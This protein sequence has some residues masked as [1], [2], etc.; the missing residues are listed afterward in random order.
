[1]STIIKGAGG[2][3]LRRYFIG[4]LVAALAIT[5][6]MFA[7]AFTTQTTTLGA[8]SISSD[9]ANVTVNNTVPNFAVLGSYRGRIPQG[10]LFEVSPSANYS[11]DLQV[12]VYLD[13]LYMSQPVLRLTSPIYTSC[14]FCVLFYKGSQTSLGHFLY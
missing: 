1:M 9:F 6:G 10:Q 11:G 3:T 8:V 2:T 7:Y 5:G 14:C 12:N 4:T 13:N